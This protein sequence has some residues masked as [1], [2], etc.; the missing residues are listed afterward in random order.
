MSIVKEAPNFVDKFEEKE[1]SEV[2]SWLEDLK[3]DGYNY[4]LSLKAKKRIEVGEMEGSTFRL[5][6]AI[7]ILKE[8]TDVQLLFDNNKNT[9][10][11][12]NIFERRKYYDNGMGY[13]RGNFTAT[14]SQEEFASWIELH[15]LEPANN[16]TKIEKLIG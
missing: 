5:L 15:E 9:D 8:K 16:V 3:A 13:G 6:S 12:Y 2:E 1:A 10:T 4:Y 7:V 11:K 14:L